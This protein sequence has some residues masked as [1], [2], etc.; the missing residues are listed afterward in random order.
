MTIL[1]NV[2]NA[3]LF[4][5]PYGKAGDVRT[6]ELDDSGKLRRFD[7]TGER[8]DQFR[9]SVAFHSSDTDDFAG[10][11][12]EGYRRETL[13]AI[14]S[15]QRQIFHP[16]NRLA[17]IVKKWMC[18][19]FLN[20]QE[21]IASNHQARELGCA[22]LMRLPAPD[23]TAVPHHRDFVRDRQNF[24]ELVRDQYDGFSLRAHSAQN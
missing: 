23:D 17:P 22:G 19:R 14:G 9:L 4:A 2:S 5:L 10:S 7:Q 3:K 15:P 20:A 11:H 21:D 12:I 8:L 6:A 24:I 16:Q 18:R 1:G 13:H